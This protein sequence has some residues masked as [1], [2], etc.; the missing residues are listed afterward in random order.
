MRCLTKL[1][2]TRDQSYRPAYH[3]KLQGLLYELLKEAGFQFIHEECPFKF[4]AFSNIFPPRD[5]TA[6]DERT[7]LVAS[8]HEPLIEEFADV[9]SPDRIIEVGDQ[10]YRVEYT[11]V[12]SVTP[13]SSGRMQT[14]TP[15]VVRIPAGRCAEY[16]IEAEYDD[17]YWRLEHPTDAFKQEVER[18]LAAKYEGYYD[19]SPPGRPYFE[20]WKSKKE[21]AVPLHYA[22]QEVQIIGTTWEFEYECRT[23]PMYRLMRM[24]YSAGL[25]ELNTTGFGFIN[26]G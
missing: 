8:P 18:N 14:G 21:V 23:R 24:A 17:V 11:S 20:T 19:E 13:D 25:G 2:A 7:W 15:I 22:E 5:M 3:V 26:P 1:R 10:G 4:V 6:G 9:L 12:F 16:G